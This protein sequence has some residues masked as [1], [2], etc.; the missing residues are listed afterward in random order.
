MASV[1]VRAV[2]N[3]ARSR[4]ARCAKAY[5][6]GVSPSCALNRRCN[7]L[8]LLPTACANSLRLGVGSACSSSRQARVTGSVAQGEGSEFSAMGVL[9]SSCGSSLTDCSPLAEKKHSDSCHLIFTP[10]L[11]GLGWR[12]QALLFSKNRF[13]PLRGW[14]ASPSATSSARLA[15]SSATGSS[16]GSCSRNRIFR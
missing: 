9:S 10:T 4:A 1:T 14:P 2:G 13:G 12:V 5:C 8:T 11:S 16:A 15:R 3:C 7:W 6:R